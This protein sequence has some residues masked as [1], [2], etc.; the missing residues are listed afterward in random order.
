MAKT[1]WRRTLIFLIAVAFGSEGCSGNGGTVN[2]SH[3]GGSGGSGAATSAPTAQPGPSAAPAGTAMQSGQIV[4]PPG[5]SL[6]MS[7][8]TVTNSVGT[9]TPKSDGT[10]SISAYTGGAQYATVTDQ[11]GTL[12]LA[13]FLGPQ[14]PT[15]DVITIGRS[16]VD[17]YGA[18]V[19]GRKPQRAE[20]V[21]RRILYSFNFS[22][23]VPGIRFVDGVIG[24]RMRRAGGTKNQLGF[25]FA[26]RLPDIFDAQDG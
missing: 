18:Q 20:I 2:L 8:L 12:V 10:F 16:S 26:V 4:L 23:Y 15:L 5:V 22:A 11:K 24:S 1:L 19:G 3:A 9:A 21:V 25:G 13:G 7:S 6:A 17:L 14:D